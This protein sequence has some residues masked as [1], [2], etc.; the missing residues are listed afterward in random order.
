MS[1]WRYLSWPHSTGENAEQHNRF[2][3]HI[4]DVCHPICWRGFL[5]SGRKW[6]AE[7][8]QREASKAAAL[9]HTLKVQ[10]WLALQAQSDAPVDIL[11]PEGVSVSD[12]A[13]EMVSHAS[14]LAD[15][16]DMVAFLRA[17]C[18]MMCSGSLL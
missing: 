16:T 6:T 14:S 10:S 8:Q 15:A 17:L 1:S 9:E 5:I 11:P 18:L 3:L 13:L 7:A 4:S 12:V 2:I